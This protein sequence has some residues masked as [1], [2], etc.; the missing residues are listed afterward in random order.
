MNGILEIRRTSQWAN[1]LREID[2]L[3]DQNKIGSVKN[4]EV[5]EYSIAPGKYILHA[6]IDSCT[7]D[8]LVIELKASER[9]CFEIGSN[10]KGRKI[11]GMLP[12]AINNK[13][14]IYLKEIA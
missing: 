2:I 6:E 13:D 3:L 14:Y 7:T 5:I 4:G 12:S 11:F 8:K 1:R 9:R 10:H